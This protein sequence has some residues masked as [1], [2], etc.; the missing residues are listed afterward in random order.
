MAGGWPTAPAAL[1]EHI[2]D[3]DILPVFQNRLLTEISPKTCGPCATKVK[4]TRGAPP[5]AIAD[6]GTS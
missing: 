2:I 5:T 1:L 4:G 3:R 6:S